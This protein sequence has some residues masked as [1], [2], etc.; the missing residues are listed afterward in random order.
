MNLSG[1]FNTWYFLAQKNAFHD[2]SNV[3]NCLTQS[4]TIRRVQ[5][6]E[7]I[8]GTWDT[9][10]VFLRI[11]YSARKLWKTNKESDLYQLCQRLANWETWTSNVEWT[12]AEWISKSCIISWISKSFYFFIQTQ[13]SITAAD[14]VEHPVKYLCSHFN[15]EFWFL[16][17]SEIL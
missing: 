6:S 16:T 5:G 8:G 1:Y 14:D 3:V 7:S 13:D 9:C 12:H 11:C 15:K 10:Q 17:S 2:Q 4:P